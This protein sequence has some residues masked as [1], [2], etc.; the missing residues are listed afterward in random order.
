MRSYSGRR[1]LSMGTDTIKAQGDVTWGHLDTF[2]H[3]S[4]QAA[5]PPMAGR[6]QPLPLPK[7]WRTKKD[8]GWDSGWDLTWWPHPRRVFSWGS[9]EGW[10]P[11][12]QGFP[13]GG[14]RGLHF[15]GLAKEGRW[16][17]WGCLSA[18]SKGVLMWFICW[19]TDTDFECVA[20]W[21]QT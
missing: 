3:L 19:I 14:C 11:V 17:I 9:Q 4:V 12:I 16:E 13:R 1:D 6:E 5:Q 2:Q 18:F 8:T 10:S 15:W 20:H 21:L 7:C